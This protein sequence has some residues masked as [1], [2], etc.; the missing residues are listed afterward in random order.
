M[1]PALIIDLKTIALSAVFA[2]ALVELAKPAL[3]LLNIP[4]KHPKYKLAVRFIALV[5]G[6]VCG[7]LVYTQLGGES[8][9]TVGAFMGICAGA[10]NA[11]LVSQIK[12]RIKKGELK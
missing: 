7:V 5:T 6:G 12:K 11:L 1:S 9:D 4:P 2:Y 10:L 8:G 3:A